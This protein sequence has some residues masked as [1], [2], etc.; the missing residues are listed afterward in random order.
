M[1]LKILQ[2]LAKTAQQNA[3]LNR[4]LLEL[5]DFYFESKQLEKAIEYYQ[6]YC[7]LYPGSR[8]SEYAGYKSILASFYTTLQPNRD[9][10]ATE[11]TIT[12]A[13]TFLTQVVRKDYKN[14]VEQII[15][16]C[17]QKLFQHEV[18]VFE[19]YLQQQKYKPAQMR[20][21]YIER[22]FLDSIKDAQRLMP[23]LKSL[24]ALVKNPDTRP[25]IIHVDWAFNLDQTAKKSSV[26]KVRHVNKVKF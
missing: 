24:L 8:E 3:Q 19:H 11:K 6:S 15:R 18:Y 21:D 13:T 25:F 14:E 23:H 12:L 1:T 26:Q 17:N 5:A 2:Q 22:H 20:L 10:T 9:I 7:A 4:Y 16:D